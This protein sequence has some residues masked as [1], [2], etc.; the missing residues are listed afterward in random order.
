MTK[1]PPAGKNRLEFEKSPYLLQH[2]DNP[3]DWYPW[4][5]EAFEKARREDKPVFLSIGYSTCHWCHVM[6]HESFEDSTVAA[7]MNKAFINIKVDREERPDIDAVYMSVCQLVRGNGGWPLTVIM[8]PEAKPFFVATY[9]PRTG[10]HGMTGMVDLVP[11]ITTMWRNRRKD[12]DV[13]SSQIAEHLETV[14]ARR[15]AS[16]GPGMETLDAA[17]SDLSARFDESNAGFGRAPKFPSPHTLLFLLRYWKRT[18]EPRALEMVERTLD[19]MARGGIYDHVGF[20]FHRYSTDERWFAPHFEKMIYDQALIAMAYTEA[21]LATGE[22]AHKRTAEEI[23][24]Y[25]LRDMTDPAGG[26]YSAEDADSEGI[27]GKHYLWTEKE[28]SSLLGED[29][30]RLIVD[31]YGVESAGN[32][33]EEVGGANILYIRRPIEKTAEDIGVEPD[34]LRRRLDG[35]RRVL[36]EARGRRVRPHKDD[37]ILTDWNGLMIAALAKAARAFG[38]DRYAAAAKKA[39]DFITASM[40]TR[41]GLLYHRYRDGEAAVAGTLDDYVFL[42]WGLIELYETTFD[43]GYLENA[44]DLTEKTIRLFWDPAAGGF[45]FTSE[46][47]EAMIVRTR[48]IYDGAIP[49]GNSAAALNLLRLARLTGTTRLED[50]ADKIGRLFHEDL[51]RAPS[52]FTWFM[53]ALDLARGPSREIVIVG[54]PDSP[55]TRAMVREVRGVYAPEAV[56][57][58][59]SSVEKSPAIT[60]LAPFT[61]SQNAIDGKATAYVCRN[62]SCG[63]PTTNAREIADRLGRRRRG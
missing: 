26:F 10:R 14:F 52:A 48:E 31:L 37:K 38:E 55:D 15:P 19:Q 4:G 44:I 40:T 17:F 18:G 5:D 58:F 54:D 9:L 2:A 50:Y 8:T 11:Q 39:V 51:T 46:D 27:E 47:G 30:A 12:V 57:L 42:A 53:A 1:I 3:V 59:K 22:E 61:R 45:Y 16:A 43:A 32:F 20:G 33:A 41:E 49:S 35:I 23:F 63:L 60:R 25:V 13:A 29:D 7:L 28:I 34:E 6:A 36:L 24:L 56:V 21:F 62:H